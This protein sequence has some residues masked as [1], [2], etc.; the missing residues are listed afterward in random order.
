MFCNLLFK[1]GSSGRF[2]CPSV[3]LSA[4][5]L[6]LCHSTPSALP[7]RP[8]K[9][10]AQRLA[11]IVWATHLDRMVP[12][13]I[14]APLHASWPWILSSHENV[15]QFC[16][17]KTYSKRASAQFH[18]QK[19]PIAFESNKRW[20]CSSRS[21]W[22]GGVALMRFLQTCQMIFFEWR[23]FLRGD[24]ICTIFRRSVT[25]L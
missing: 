20:D 6:A 21:C 22:F 4:W 19:V 14:P 10:L 25:K 18:S 3:Q 8:P 24:C 9:Y 12:F 1:S 2:W 17:G 16:L 11:H 23:C 5:D 7:I 15:F 13:L